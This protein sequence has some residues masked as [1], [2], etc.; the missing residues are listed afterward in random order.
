MEKTIQNDAVS[1]MIKN[2]LIREKKDLAV[3]HHASKSAHI[4]NCN[5]SIYINLS[6]RLTTDYL[7]LTQIT[8][9]EQFTA[10]CYLS[11]P[12]WLDYTVESDKKLEATQHGGHTVLRLP[13][14]FDQWKI[15]ISTPKNPQLLPPQG[16]IEIRESF[17]D[18][19][20]KNS[21][22]TR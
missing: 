15:K 7:H 14:G 11:L 8:G 10:D 22:E 19:R 6:K 21:G 16:Y 17:N 3:Y 9:N 18:G 13:S 1:I 4:V 5:S 12:S 2:K 20:Q